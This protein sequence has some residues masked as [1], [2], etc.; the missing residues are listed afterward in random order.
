MS[1]LDCLSFVFA[2]PVRAA[3]FVEKKNCLLR[4]RVNKVCD[5]IFLVVIC[6]IKALF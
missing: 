1:Y 4:V 2:I 3:S 5:K 6:Y